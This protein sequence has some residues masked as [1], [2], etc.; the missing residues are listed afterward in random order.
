MKYLFLV[1][2]LL[3]V[4]IPAFGAS[5]FIGPSGTILTP[6]GI[7]VPSGTWEVGFHR[8]EVGDGVNVFSL[9]YGLVPNFEVGVALENNGDD[10]FSVNAKYRI[11]QESA[12]QPAVLVGMHNFEDDTSVYILGS[13]TLS[14]QPI[15]LNI[16]LGS[17]FYD[18]VFAGAELVV[19]PRARIMAEIVD[20]DFNAG[21]R[22]ALTDTIRLDAALIDLDD[23]AFGASLRAPF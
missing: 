3:V 8:F 7:V 17:G 18:G 5:S 1:A 15:T 20:S 13:K 12:T 11:V 6:D 23:F 4:A 10:D 14:G 2:I 22:Y 21:I 19:S 9:N 16:G